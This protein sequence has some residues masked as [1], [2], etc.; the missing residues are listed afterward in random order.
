M[1][2]RGG[3]SRGVSPVRVACHD[4]VPFLRHVRH[5]AGAVA[6]VAALG[7]CSGKAESST[8]NFASTRSGA[9]GRVTTE[10][11]SIAPRHGWAAVGGRRR[12]GDGDRA[13]ALLRLV[14]FRLDAA[15]RERLRSEAVRHRDLIATISELSTDEYRGHAGRPLRGPLRVRPGDF[16]TSG[17]QQVPRGHAV[18]KRYFSTRGRRFSLEVEFGRPR[19]SRGVERELNRNLGT[20]TVAER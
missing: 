17:S 7:A 20:L 2:S 5:V 10:G 16:L 14:N 4:Y 19:P 18:A 8:A 12:T 9:S 13:L 3:C 1:Q 15:G 6:C 11:V